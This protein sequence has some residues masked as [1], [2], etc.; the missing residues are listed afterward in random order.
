MDDLLGGMAVTW[1]V[2]RTPELHSNN[3]LSGCRVGNK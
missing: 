3:N 1:A 2:I